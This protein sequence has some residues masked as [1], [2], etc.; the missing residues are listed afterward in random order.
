MFGTGGVT[1]VSPE[2]SRRTQF[3]LGVVPTTL[4]DSEPTR[5]GGKGRADLARW[6]RRTL[7]LDTFESSRFLVLALRSEEFTCSLAAVAVGEESFAAIAV[8][9]G[10]SSGGDSLFSAR[11]GSALI[12]AWLVSD[13]P[14]AGTGGSAIRLLAANWGEE[15]SLSAVTDVGGGDA[16][17]VGDC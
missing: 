13:G 7:G 17:C 10:K 16:V 15:E 12:G 9:S 1:I 4:A 3:P 8:R 6:R 11:G 2:G 14:S 5:R